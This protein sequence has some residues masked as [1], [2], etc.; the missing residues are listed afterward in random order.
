MS[1]PFLLPWEGWFVPALPT[2]CPPCGPPGE[3]LQSWSFYQS[4]SRR[5]SLFIV[6]KASRVC[7][8]LLCVSQGGLCSRR[9]V[10]IPNRLPLTFWPTMD[11][12]YSTII[13]AQKLLFLR[14]IFKDEAESER[15]K[16]LQ[17]FNLSLSQT[18]VTL[19]KTGGRMR[20]NLVCK[21]ECEWM[22]Q[23]SQ[24]ELSN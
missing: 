8:R 9:H 24:T 22:N 23:N 15:Q 6:M 17:P 11:F 13:A 21:Q 18:G 12:S 2:F 19:P 5:F 7:H 16:P 4:A 14:L 20:L 10:W 3:Q 1:F